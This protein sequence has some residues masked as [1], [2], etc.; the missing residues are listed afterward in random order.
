MLGLGAAPLAATLIKGE[1][2]LPPQAAQLS[3][4]NANIQ[5]TANSYL[6]GVQNNTPTPPQAA[7]L[8][9]MQQQLTNQW[10]QTLFN[11]GVTNPQSDTRWPQIQAQIDQQVT[12]AAQSMIQTNLQAALGLSGQ[13][14]GNLIALANM[15]IQQD[16]AF[17]NSITEA[18]KALGTVAALGAASKII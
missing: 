12:A 8:A 7:A 3:A 17:Q 1:S 16:T 6:A 4:N 18:T 10:A 2:P 15:Q 5:A 14:S 11:Q 13:A 9:T